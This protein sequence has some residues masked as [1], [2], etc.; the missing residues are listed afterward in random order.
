M[1]ASACNFIGDKKKGFKSIEG[2]MKLLKFS[3][4][5]KAG[6]NFVN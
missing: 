2:G 6:L 1:A 3:A 5:L 4:L